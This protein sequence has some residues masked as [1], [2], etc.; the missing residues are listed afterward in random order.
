MNKKDYP[1][2]AIKLVDKYFPKGHKQRGDAL[3]ILAIAF[4]EGQRIKKGKEKMVISDKDLEKIWQGLDTRITTI[5]ERTKIH[6]I[7]IRELRK[8]IKELKN[9]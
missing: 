8:K 4:Y 2:E 5:N 9:E 6:T 7:E 3:V 1:N